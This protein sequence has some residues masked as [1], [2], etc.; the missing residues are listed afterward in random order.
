[1]DDLVGVKIALLLDD[2]LIVMQRDNKPGLRF[3]GLWDFPG[4]GRENH[5]SPSEC[6]IREIGEELNIGLAPSSI[7][8]QKIHPAMHDPKVDAYF[9]VAKVTPA[10]VQAINLGEGRGWKLMPINEFMDASDVV[11]PLKGRLQDYLN[12]RI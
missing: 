5:E 10:D 7:I 2:K 6:A 3:A 1:M 12:S 8:W 9:M 4:G 11:E